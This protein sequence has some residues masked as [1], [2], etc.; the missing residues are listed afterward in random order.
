MRFLLSF[1]SKLRSFEPRLVFL[2]RLVRNFN[3]D[4]VYSIDLKHV[5]AVFSIAHK[6]FGQPSSVFVKNQDFEVVWDSTNLFL[7]LTKK[8]LIQTS[9]IEIVTL[10]NPANN[11]KTLKARCQPKGKIY[12]LC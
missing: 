2:Y 12:I 10:N 9:E 5:G 7:R 11:F 8:M 6:E 3:E 4:I 1:I